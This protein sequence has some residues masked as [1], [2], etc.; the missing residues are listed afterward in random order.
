LPPGLRL[1][2]LCIQ[3]ASEADNFNV[4][5]VAGFGHPAALFDY[6]GA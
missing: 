4:Q 1:Y 2:R 6:P 3:R 5:T